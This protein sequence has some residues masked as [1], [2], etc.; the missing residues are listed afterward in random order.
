MEYSQFHSLQLFCFC[1]YNSIYIYIMSIVY[2]I[3]Y[4][5]FN[6]FEFIPILF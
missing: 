2:N 5:L 4:I 3:I 1:R 6:I